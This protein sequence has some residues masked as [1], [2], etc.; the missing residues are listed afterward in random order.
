MRRIVLLVCVIAA[1]FLASCDSPKEKMYSREYVEQEK[2]EAYNRGYAD[3]EYYAKGEFERMIGE[4]VDSGYNRGYENGY[5][6]GYEDGCD[7]SLAGETTYD[8]ENRPRIKK[9]K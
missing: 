4:A 8:P 5:E 7:D 9:D 2:Y 6:D 3:G 1:L